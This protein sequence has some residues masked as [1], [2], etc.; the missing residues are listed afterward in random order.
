LHPSFVFEGRFKSI[1]NMKL[2][3]AILICLSAHFAFCD[4]A[5]EGEYF[6]GDMELTEE[7]KIAIQMSIDGIPT[8]GATSYRNWPKRIPYAIDG[9]L[10]STA[11]TK[12]EEAIRDYH[13]YTC[14]RFYP[15]RAEK[16]Y[17]YFT[18]GSGCSSPV[19]YRGTYNSIRLAS[20]CWR[21]G[22]II[23]EM[24]HSLGFFHEQSRP[25]RD[26][27]VRI[28]WGNIPRSK[29]HNFKKYSTSVIKSGKSKYDYLSVMHYGRTAFGNGKV[30]IDATN[31]Y[32]DRKIGQ[33]SGFSR[34]D[35]NQ[36]RAK[37]RC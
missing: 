7:Q 32:Y 3:L 35:I 30:T 27:Y 34:E 16:A 4:E 21:K 26:N 36:V 2:I 15:R 5:E 11:K 10:G 9:R 31:N 37:Y 14:L 19:G 8:Y 12:I 1:A 25:D 18:T 17:F 13:K 23:H 22:I 33:R 28:I 20:G 29:Q 6:E 24:M